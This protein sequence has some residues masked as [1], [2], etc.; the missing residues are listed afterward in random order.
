MRARRKKRNKPHFVKS[1]K[2]SCSPTPPRTPHAH[3]QISVYN[4]S[5]DKSAYLDGGYSDVYTYH[6]GICVCV[7]A[8]LRGRLFTDAH[9]MHTLSSK[10]VNMIS[11]PIKH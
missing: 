3:V 9:I 6:D 2:K 7:Y 1:D 5:A 4:A 8:R 10:S 11:Q